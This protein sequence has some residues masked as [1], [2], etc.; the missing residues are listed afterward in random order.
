M[1]VE[2]T[3]ETITLALVLL[4]NIAALIWGAA[5]LRTSVNNLEGKVDSWVERFTV[6]VDRVTDALTQHGERLAKLEGQAKS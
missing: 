5:T 2:I 1:G 3:P 6:Q 4:G